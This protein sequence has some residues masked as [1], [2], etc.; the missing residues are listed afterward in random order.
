MNDAR[1]WKII[2]G[3][4]WGAAVASGE[5]R[6]YERIKAEFIENYSPET[7]EEFNDWYAEKYRDLDNAHSNECAEGRNYGNYGGDDSYSDMLNHVIG[8][9]EVY[10]AAIM[11]NMALLG[12][13]HPQESFSYCIPHVG[14]CMPDYA[15][16][17][18]EDVARLITATEVAED[19]FWNAVANFYPEVKSGDFPPDV[20]MEM[21]SNLARYIKVWLEEN[22]PTAE[23]TDEPDTVSGSTEVLF[24]NIEYTFYNPNQEICN[25]VE[26]IAYEI[27]TGCKSG[28]LFFTNFANKGGERTVV[29]EWEIN[30]N[31]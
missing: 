6:P 28:E 9:G 29:G 2:E 10:Y 12:K 20:A 5:H 16:K 3:M 26:Q 24:H 31:G 19:M 30:N 14:G 15:P 18:S 11:Y 4:G 25:H 17:L 27:T 23:S 7:A 13:L 21:S 1:G 22:E 8:L